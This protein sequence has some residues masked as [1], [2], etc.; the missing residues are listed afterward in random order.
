[1]S[2]RSSDLSLPQGILKEKDVS[3]LE[4]L[5]EDDAHFVEFFSALELDS[6][7][8]KQKQRAS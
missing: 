4:K 7:S 6:V 3:E 5:Q 2:S 8:Y 1:M